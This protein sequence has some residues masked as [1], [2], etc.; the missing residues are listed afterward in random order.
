VSRSTR[1]FDVMQALRRSRE[2]VAGTELAR[3]AGVSVRTIYRDIASLQAIGADIEGE[4]GVGYVLRPGFLLPPLTFTED[5][6][7]ALAAGAKWVSR[8]TDDGL[9][10]AAQDAIAKIRAVLPPDMRHKTDDDA[11]YVGRPS[12]KPPAWDIQIVRRAMREQRKMRIVYADPSGKRSERVIWPIMLGFLESRRYV[13]G[14]CELRDD[15]RMFRADRIERAKVLSERYTRSRRTL[16]REW[17]AKEDA[18]R[19]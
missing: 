2:P 17:R 19:A 5:E 8:Q 6:I 4:P 1:L 11:L 7:Q 3:Q 10:R 15:F 12:A 14:W 18:K 9:A 16:V 13:A